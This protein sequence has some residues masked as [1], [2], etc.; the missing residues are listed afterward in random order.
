[1]PEALKFTIGG[2]SDP[3]ER[4]LQ[5]AE[6]I[7]VK[8]SRNITRNIEQSF[9]IGGPNT[10]STIFNATQGRDASTDYVAFWQKAFK[11]RE[12]AETKAAV[13]GAGRRNRLRAILRSRAARDEAR[14]AAQNAEIAAGSVPENMRGANAA[15]V[16][17]RKGRLNVASSMFVSVARDASASLASGADPITVFLQQAPQIGQA[18]TMIG[19]RF[20]L[21]TGIVGGLGLAVLGL[22]LGINKLVR[23]FYDVDNVRGEGLRRRAEGYRKLREEA[24]LAREAEKKLREEITQQTIDAAD[25][26]ERYI[27]L[28]NR[29][30]AAR[31]KT[32]EEAARFTKVALEGEAAIA[33]DRLRR[34]EKTHDLDV[35]D[36]HRLAPA[37]KEKFFRLKSD[38]E[39]A[40]QAIEEQDRN[41]A[42]G[43]KPKDS[44][45][46][47][48][49]RSS[50][51]PDVTDRQRMNLMAVGNSPM[52]DETRTIN[53]NL[54]II[55][56]KM[57]R[58]GSL[59]Q[60]FG[61]G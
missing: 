1:M 11:E 52:L 31:A 56:N 18:A 35:V 5:R 12:E 9:K 55:I 10:K 30:R 38:V 15:G 6:Q 26:E 47:S 3:F 43:E 42:K 53:K 49:G 58:G 51:S 59:N 33:Q 25:A 41:A 54:R 60:H 50:G 40:Q 37:D 16:L 45:M 46:E 28:L 36:P 24:D 27:A 48:T 34:F 22:G 44:R 4:E 39:R 7:S 19:G 21:L 17:G 8:Y 32:A 29:G 2:S 23:S 61:G 14:T 13:E 57:G 20:L